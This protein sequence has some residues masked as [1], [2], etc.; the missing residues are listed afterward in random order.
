MDM[1]DLLAPM[2]DTLGPLGAD[3]FMMLGTASG[4]GLNFSIQPSSSSEGG[5]RGSKRR[6]GAAAEDEEE[7]CMQGGSCST[8]NARY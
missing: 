2:G 7:V 8:K 4:S 5:S 1:E 6:R 3:D